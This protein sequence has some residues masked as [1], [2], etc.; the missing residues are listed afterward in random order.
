MEETKTSPYHLQGNGM[1]ERHNRVIADVILK[2]CAGNANTWD[3][4]LPNLS[5]V[6][7][8]TVHRTT[9]HTPF[10]LVYGQ[11]CKYPIDL[12]LPMAPKRRVHEEQEKTSAIRREENHQMQ[13]VEEVQATEL[14]GH[15]QRESMTEANLEPSPPSAKQT[16]PPDTTDQQSTTP[17]KTFSTEFKNIHRP[18]NS[19]ELKRTLMTLNFET[20]SPRLLFNTERRPKWAKP[21]PKRYRIDDERKHES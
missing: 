9:W 4:M 7:N 19:K 21:F 6:Y 1:V 2:Y 12:L 13:D 8:S 11:E 18:H 3:V 20:P 17:Y 15:N 10:S 5:F 14:T 16:D